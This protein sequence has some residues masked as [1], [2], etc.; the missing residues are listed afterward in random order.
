MIIATELS[1][2]VASGSSLGWARPTVNLDLLRAHSNR[3]EL[4]NDLV[5]T[6]RQ[7]A[8][9]QGESGG[10]GRQ[11]ALNGP[12]GARTLDER[13]SEADQTALVASFLR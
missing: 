6:E 12:G 1:P 5:R 7:L 8:K 4:L 13:L 9:A 2:A 11:R 10:Y 3:R